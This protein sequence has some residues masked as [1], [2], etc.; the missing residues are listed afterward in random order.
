MGPKADNSGAGNS[1]RVTGDCGMDLQDFCDG[2]VW[3][4]AP[5]AM[6]QMLTALPGL[7]RTERIDT[8][9]VKVREEQ[10]YEPELTVRDGVAVIP[11]TGS[12]S[13][14]AGFLS[15]LFGEA[16]I[17]RIRADLDAAMADRRV[18]A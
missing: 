10:A 14:R 3:A 4:I 13:K 16:S 1:G 2:S 17:D 9:A 12:I 8:A 11:V 7:L 15:F 18:R 6:D 5:E